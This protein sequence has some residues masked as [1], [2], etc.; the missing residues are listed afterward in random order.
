MTPTRKPFSV[1]TPSPG[2][3]LANEWWQVRDAAAGEVVGYG[4]L[5]NEWGDAEITFVVAADRRG[6]G[7]GEFIVTR[8]EQEA[9]A[10]GLNY[11]YNEVPASH[12]DR[13]WMT[14][15]LIRHGFVASASGDGILRRRVGAGETARAMMS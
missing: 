4:W 6:A 9:A 15:W 14:A 12:P 2:A 13:A 11:I 3:V 7:V 1:P 10:R 8:L 5:D